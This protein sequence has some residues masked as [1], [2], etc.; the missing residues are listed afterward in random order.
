MY[1]WSVP[2]T[3]ATGGAQLAVVPLGTSL[4]TRESM[5]SRGFI[6]VKEQWLAE[7]RSVGARVFLAANNRGLNTVFLVFLSQIGRTKLRLAQVLGP[8]GQAAE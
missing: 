3:L 7:F 8:N 2:E 1:V 4:D 5:F 6:L